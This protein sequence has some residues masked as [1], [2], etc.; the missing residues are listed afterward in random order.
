MY[1]QRKYT[2]EAEPKGYPPEVREKAVQMYVDGMNYRRI[3]RHL[4]IS[5]QTVYRWV[6][7]YSEELPP[8]PRPDKVET[9]ELDEVYTYIG[10]KKTGSSS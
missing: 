1:C 7:A 9:A 4:N 5:H 3:A 2:P 8:P 10:D 6:R